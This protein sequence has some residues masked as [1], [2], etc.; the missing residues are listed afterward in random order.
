M[1]V[2]PLPQN[3]HVVRPGTAVLRLHSSMTIKHVF[4]EIEA[5]HS[6]RIIDNYA[7]GGAVAAVHYLEPTATQD[8]EIFVSGA[9][10]EGEHVIIGD[11]PVQI[12]AKWQRFEQAY[13]NEA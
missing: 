2:W 4:S 11:W 7:L 1:R 12:L 9:K 5:L 8:V 10:V 6:A 13:R 3:R